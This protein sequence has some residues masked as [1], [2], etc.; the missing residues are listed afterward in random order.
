M[1]D[2]DLVDELERVRQEWAA[3][4]A[5]LIGLGGELKATRIETAVR[6]EGVKA[7]QNRARRIRLMYVAGVGSAV[8]YGYDA[9]VAHCSPG[10]RVVHAV[11]WLLAHPP[12]PTDT[13]AQRQADFQ[14]EYD[15][16]PAWCDVVMPLHTHNG[17]HY[18]QPANVIGMTLVALLAVGVG[19]YHRHRTRKDFAA[20]GEAAQKEGIHGDRLPEE[21]E[22]GPHV[23][24]G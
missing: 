16:A 13:P 14:R 10:A 24:A 6:V 5:V 20:V 23:D 3:A 12:K 9:Q 1:T 19:V 21:L 17:S 15:S 2:R 4:S 22:E 8:I 18:P 11:D 7:E